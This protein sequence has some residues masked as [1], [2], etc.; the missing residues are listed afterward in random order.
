MV[1]SRTAGPVNLRHINLWWAWTPG[2][3]WRWPEGRGSS[4]SGREDHP[5]VHVGYEDAEA[6]AN[7][8]G[9]ELPSEAE[10][11]A[12][13]RGGLEQTIFTWGDEAE[14]LGDRLANFWHGDF[15]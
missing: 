13:A 11:E 10:W 1:F 5:V 12:A 7:W 15:P 3:S 8:A 9:R 6:Y 14:S 2:A 4:I